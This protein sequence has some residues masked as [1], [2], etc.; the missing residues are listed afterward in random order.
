[1]EPRVV[2]LSTSCM[3]S[4]STLGLPAH[5]GSGA[6]AIVRTSRNESFF[7]MLTKLRADNAMLLDRFADPLRRPV[8]SQLEVGM[9]KGELSEQN[10]LDRIAL[11]RV[12]AELQDVG[13]LPIPKAVKL[14]SRT[15]Q[16]LQTRLRETHY[17]TLGGTSLGGGKYPKIIERRLLR[18]LPVARVPNCAFHDSN[19]LGHPGQRVWHNALLADSASISDAHFFGALDS[20]YQAAREKSRL[21]ARGSP[22]TAD[23][24]AYLRACVG[25]RMGEL[26]EFLVCKGFDDETRRGMG[27]P[28]GRARTSIA[29]YDI[30]CSQLPALRQAAEA[31]VRDKEMS[32]TG[33]APTNERA[34]VHRRM[35]RLAD[36]MGLFLNQ[37]QAVIAAA[38]RS[39]RDDPDV[40]HALQAIVRNM[41]AS[42]KS[43]DG[44]T[45]ADRAVLPANVEELWGTLGSQCERIHRV[46]QGFLA[47]TGRSCSLAETKR[48]MRKANITCSK[49]VATHDPVSIAQHFAARQKKTVRM[50]E[51]LFSAYAFSEG[52]DYKSLF[53]VMTDKNN[54]GRGEMMVK[55]EKRETF[56]HGAGGD[57]LGKLALFSTLLRPVHTTDLVTLFEG[58]V[59]PEQIPGWTRDFFSPHPGLAVAFGH[60]CGVLSIPSPL[61]YE[62]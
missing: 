52:L 32:T 56:A 28:D 46:L 60:V 54:R 23:D 35:R 20:F 55:N 4:L 29:R 9:V 30:V 36:E 10:P 21:E 24:F 6:T 17:P 62:M 26:L 15:R 16:E 1:M 33:A 61:P 49:Y 37:T 7:D 43:E 19:I 13:I 39:V 22:L 34:A 25:G 5:V 42:F 44:F 14:Y 47:D 8:Q 53:S 48:L 45:P 40:L 18:S 57:C 27:I 50:I 59:Q 58:D 31:Q 3:A 41:G 38:K 11:L 2:D 51:V 12:A